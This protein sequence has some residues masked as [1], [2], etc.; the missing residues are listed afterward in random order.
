MKKFFL[1]SALLLIVLS[2][3][4]I[5]AVADNGN[6]NTDY[7]NGEITRLEKI[8]LAL[9]DKITTYNGYPQSVD[10]VTIEP[11]YADTLTVFYLYKTI[12]QDNEPSDTPPTTAGEYEVTAYTNETA[13]YEASL[14]TAKLIIE[15]K[16][17]AFGIKDKTVVYSG[18]TVSVEADIQEELENNVIIYYE[19]IEETVFENT[20]DSPVDAGIYKVSAVYEESN[21]FEKK[22]VYSK[23]VIERKEPIFNIQDKRVKYSGV[24]V[25]VSPEIVDRPADAEILIT[26]TGVGSTEYE[27]TDI[28]PKDAGE[29]KVTATLKETPNYTSKTISSS[30]IIDKYGKPELTLQNKTVI[31]NKNPQ[32]VDNAIVLPVFASYLPVTY[33]YKADD[34]PESEYPPTNSGTYIVK[35]STPDDRN[36]DPNFVT[37]VLIIEKAEQVITF[38]DISPKKW[39]DNPFNLNVTVDT[40]F[41]IIYEGSNNQVAEVADDG[42]VAINCS[43]NVTFTVN[44]EETRNYLPATKTQSIFVTSSDTDIYDL[45]INGES[46]SLGTQMYYDMYCAE[47]TQLDIAIDTECNA[48][49]DKGHVFTEIIEKPEKRKVVFTVTSQDQTTSKIYTLIIEKRFKFEDIINIRWNNTLSVINNP[50]NNGG[51]NFTSFKW[52]RKTAASEDFEVVSEEQ[53][54]SVGENGEIIQPDDVF[55]VEITGKEFDDILRT[56]ENSPAIQSGN[57]SIK[58]YP[59]PVS[60]DQ[61]LKVEIDLEDEQLKDAEIEI[62]NVNGMLIRVQKVAEKQT[63][64]S[65]LNVSGTHILRLKTKEEKGNELRIMVK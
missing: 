57:S 31:Y 36:F 24:V 48:T 11:A 8:T 61:D 15:K 55:Y 63:L 59:I 50:E 54:Y 51:Y 41:P 26:Y 28:A 58:A 22:T 33:T 42:T 62:Y 18:Q 4:T 39:K 56:C 38:P 30:L 1:Q 65:P 20:T 6:D 34:Y 7:E 43:G 45:R 12:G 37:A 17:P 46:I 21:N 5:G 14:V 13:Q 53:Y 35:A 3:G 2:C 27:E 19:G 9:D 25:P 29:Y 23:L 44:V 64:I 49:I 32:G 52:Y 40:G 10:K 60:R 16:E 47:I